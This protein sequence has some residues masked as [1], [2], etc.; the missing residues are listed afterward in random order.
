MWAMKQT[1]LNSNS[2]QDTETKDNRVTKNLRAEIMRIAE[3]ESNMEKLLAMTKTA[4][5]LMESSS[6]KAS[7]KSKSPRKKSPKTP[8]RS[9][10]EPQ[11][12]S[13]L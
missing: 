13:G 2:D 6:K 12:S 1:N 11:S 5:E 10:K 3:V 8:K 7:T 9:K 4:D